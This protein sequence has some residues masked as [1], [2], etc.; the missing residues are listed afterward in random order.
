MGL[1]SN[2]FIVSLLDPFRDFWVTLFLLFHLTNDRSWVFNTRWAQG[3]S[4]NSCRYCLGHI[5]Q[6]SGFG[7]GG[8]I[9]GFCNP[10]P[11]ETKY[12]HFWSRLRITPEL[13]VI[14][15]KSIEVFVL[16][17][18]WLGKRQ[19][20]GDL[21]QSYDKSP[22]THGNV[23]RAVTTQTTPQKS[24]IKQRLRTDLG[25]SVGV[26]TVTQ[27]VWLTGLRAHLPTPR[28]SRV[29]TPINRHL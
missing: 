9:D 6:V 7:G 14:S 3:L 10:P 5:C 8:V 1:F 29:L 2:Q 11:R 22:Y 21:T 26:T 4:F 13:H 25:R 16:Q 18:L 28:N 23:K 24:S 12:L 15:L 27:L 17:Q 20:G 19:K